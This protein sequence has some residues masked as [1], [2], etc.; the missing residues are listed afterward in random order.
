MNEI[1]KKILDELEFF[2]EELILIKLKDH[3]DV[4]EEPASKYWRKYI[5]ISKRIGDGYLPNNK[6]NY[7]ARIWVCKDTE[8]H[9]ENGGY[10]GNSLNEYEFREYAQTVE[11]RLR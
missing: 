1:L 2:H 10:H 11:F 9:W 3:P 8:G 7:T 4:L 5:V 6:R